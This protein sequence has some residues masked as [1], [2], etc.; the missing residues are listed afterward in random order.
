[1][2]PNNKNYKNEN[3][4][5]VMNMF[6][7]A[8]HEKIEI[9]SKQESPDFMVESLGRKIGI[10]LTEVFQ[11]SNMGYSRLQQYS[12]DSSA[13]VDDLINLI[14]PHIDFTFFIGIDF[15]RRFPL[16]KSTRKLVL[17]RTKEICIPAMISLLNHEWIE[18][19]NYYHGLP[20]EIEDIYLS[21]FDGMGESSNYQ[22]EGGSV[23]NL[24]LAHIRP[25][26]DKKEQ[27]LS[28]YN[29]CESYWLLIREGNY[30]AG[31]FGDIDIN[32]PICSRFDKVFLLR[33]RTQT[34]IELK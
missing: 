17:Q 12:S 25:I 24:T 6:V 23:A 2:P 1:M 22:P 16:K 8:Y 15:N 3:E 26:L 31:S 30:Y 34:L 9:L 33:T 27:K 28:T 29:I 13:F 4:M 7:E 11:D 10:E 18:L 19:D 5:W 32:I 20:D 21:R 14:Q